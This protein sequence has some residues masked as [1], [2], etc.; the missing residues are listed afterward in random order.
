MHCGGDHRAQTLA[1]V[2]RCGWAL[3]YAAEELK[4]DRAIVQKAVE[5]DGRALQYAAEEL[6][7]DPRGRG[8]PGA[9]GT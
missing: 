4:G 7:G 9:E 3:E 8:P 5:Q 2:E 1:A 6:K